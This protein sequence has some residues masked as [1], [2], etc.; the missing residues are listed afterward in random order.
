MGACVAFPGPVPHQRT[1]GS[2]G[3]WGEQRELLQGTGDSLDEAALGTPGT[4]EICAELSQAN[5]QVLL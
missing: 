4:A 5:D 2:G 3:L 1:E